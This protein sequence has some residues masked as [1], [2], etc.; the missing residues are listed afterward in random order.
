MIIG[1]ILEFVYLRLLLDRIRWQMRLHGLRNCYMGS[2]QE[3][4][5][6]ILTM[7]KRF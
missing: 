3:Q 1:I 5:L 2:D 4:A 6:Q 7:D